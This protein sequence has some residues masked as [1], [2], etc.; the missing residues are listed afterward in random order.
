[1]IAATLSQAW[2][3]YRERLGVIAAVVIAIWLPCNLFTSYMD[4]YFFDPEKI[5]PSMKMHQFIENFIGIIATGAITFIAFSALS[6]KQATFG[7]AM[8]RGSESWSR[9]WVT[10][11]CLG[12]VVL[13]SLLLFIIPGIYV[14]TRLCFCECVAVLEKKSGSDALKRSWAITKNRFWPLFAL[15]SVTLLIILAP[16]GMIQAAEYFI[17]ELE[18][19]IIQAVLFLISDLVAVYG[20]FVF[21]C[22]YK[23]YLEEDLRLLESADPSTIQASPAA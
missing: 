22:A 20:T 19:W 18:Y 15:G 14:Y 4:A 17:P 8:E 6:D 1:M 13:L 16:F 12:F 23:T 7:Q 3:I 11:F 5:M 10:R 21:I 9:L 2:R